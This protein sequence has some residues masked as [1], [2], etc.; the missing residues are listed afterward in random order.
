MVSLLTCDLSL[1]KQMQPP[2]DFLSKFY[3]GFI[4]VHGRNETHITL[5]L[6]LVFCFFYVALVTWLTL[7]SEDAGGIFLRNIGEI[8]LDYMVLHSRR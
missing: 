6:F 5:L 2:F 7:D 8:L 3:S 4:T 1:A